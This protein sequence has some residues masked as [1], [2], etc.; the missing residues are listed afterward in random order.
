MLLFGFLAVSCTDDDKDKGPSPETS[1]QTEYNGAKYGIKKGFYQEGGPMELIGD[2]ESHFNQNFFL[3]DGNVTLK[4]D[5]TFENAADAKILFMTGLLSPGTT[6]FQNGVYEYSNIIQDETNLS[7]AEFEAKYRNR[8][9]MLLS[10]VLLDTDGDKNFEEEDAQTVTGGTLKVLGTKPNYT[11]E[12]DLTFTGGK[13]L[14][15]KYSGS[16]QQVTD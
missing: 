9:V 5:G 4:D 14:K 8:N 10:F 13:T 6:G 15:G 2:E 12:Y 1:K 16:Y 7:E 11:L 3:T